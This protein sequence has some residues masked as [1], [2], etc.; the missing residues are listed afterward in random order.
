MKPTIKATIIGLLLL[1]GVSIFSLSGSIKKYGKAMIGIATPTYEAE[2]PDQDKDGLNDQDEIYWST[3]PLNPD[4]DEDGYIDGEEILSGRNP[5]VP[6]PNDSLDDV[7]L[8][9]KFSSLTVAGFA[10]GDLRLDEPSK[11]EG[12]TNISLSILDQAVA[13]F[14]SR[15]FRT[16]IQKTDDTETNKKKYVAE[17]DIALKNFFKIFIEESLFIQNEAAVK[18]SVNVQSKSIMDRFSAYHAHTNKSFDSLAE[19]KVPTSWVS[20]HESTLRMV[21]NIDG[22]NKALSKGSEDPVKATLGLNRLIEYY[23]ISS[24]IIQSLRSDIEKNNIPTEG[25]IFER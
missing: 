19:I 9:D 5:T 1:A 14:E 20:H 17:M 10:Q 25:T 11:E 2:I 24:Q 7:N 23:D 6:A 18:G 3:D 22:I 16:Q 15:F 8:T 4:T 13:S 12:L 21:S